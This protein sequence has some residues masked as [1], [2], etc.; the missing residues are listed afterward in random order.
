MLAIDLKEGDKL[1][2]AS[3]GNGV[4]VHKTTRTITARF[5]FVTT[6]WNFRNGCTLF[7]LGIKIIKD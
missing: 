5:D 3:K 4:I 2:N 1:Y 6:K 7:E